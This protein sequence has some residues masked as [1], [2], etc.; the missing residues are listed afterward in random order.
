MYVYRNLYIYQY[1][2]IYIYISTHL[3]IY[4]SI[5]IYL[6]IYLSVYLSTYS[7]RER[8]KERE[9]VFVCI[10]VIKRRGGMDCDGRLTPLWHQLPFRLEIE[11]PGV[12]VWEVDV[13]LPGTGNSNFHGA[14]LVHLI[15]TVIQW[16]R[17]SRLSIA[18]VP[19][20]VPERY[21]PPGD[22]SVSMSLLGTEAH[23]C[24]HRWPRRSPYLLS[25][26]PT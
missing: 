25:T 8:K 17:T 7:E 19:F 13:R 11:P 24:W 10:C 1:I 4:I 23:H 9:C 2:Y 21:I 6:S 18:L 3:Y 20:L 26:H 12:N 15:I 16:I 22:L 5:S 14:R